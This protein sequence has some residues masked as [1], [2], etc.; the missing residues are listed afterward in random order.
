MPKYQIA[1]YM[2]G[3]MILA[4]IELSQV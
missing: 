4:L 3:V 1:D 2:Y